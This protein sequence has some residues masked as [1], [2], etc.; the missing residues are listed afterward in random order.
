MAKALYGFHGGGD[1][2]LE[3][4]LASLRAR[5]R[6]LEAEVAALRAQTQMAH[7]DLD[8]LL[9]TQDAALV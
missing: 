1:P 5:V 7:D 6:E 2:R 9:T 4:E 8:L 3:A